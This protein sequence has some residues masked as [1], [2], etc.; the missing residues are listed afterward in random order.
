MIKQE[1]FFSDEGKLN[2]KNKP[3]SIINFRPVNDRPKRF[4]QKRAAFPAQR[5]TG[6]VW[7]LFLF[8]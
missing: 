6:A 8:I 5:G 1:R 3:I 4:I 7:H 2:E